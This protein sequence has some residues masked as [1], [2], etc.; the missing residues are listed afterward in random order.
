MDKCIMVGCDLHDKS[1]LL[2][3]AS[4]RLDEAPAAKRLWANNAGAR[5]AMRADLQRRAAEVGARR[6][7]F[8]YEASGLGFGLHDELTAAGIECHVLAPTKMERSIKN[9]FGKTDERDADAVLRDV[10]SYVLSGAELP[11]VWV[12][13]LSIR[14]DREP[15]RLRLEAADKLTR[16]KCQIRCLL[17]RSGVEQAASSAKPWTGE[18]VRWLRT[19]GESSGR[20]GAGA[21]LASL[22]RQMDFAVEE[23]GRLDAVVEAL[24]KTARYAPLM[25]AMRTKG[26]G[27]LTAMVLATELGDFGRFKNRRQFGAFL[28]LAPRSD[29]SGQTD[30]R[31]GRITRQGPSRVRK[32]LNQAIWSRVRAGG[33]DAAKYGRIAA[34]NPKHKKKAV[35][36]VMRDLGIWE[37]HRGLEAQLQMGGGSSGAAGPGGPGG[38]GGASGGPK[39]EVPV[40]GLAGA[41]AAAALRLPGPAA[42]GA[43]G[44][45]P[46]ERC[47]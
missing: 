25:A 42:A 13:P 24:S 45:A 8:A 30:D 16:I 28:G 22:L 37:W 3:I 21:A 17:K 36:A 14:D 7:V 43:S 32:V 5:R 29:E 19:W 40:V 31:K 44:D 33:P 39:R 18:Y 20:P 11:E 27:L 1:M 34:R 41:A 10:V 35:V 26:V 9:L 46:G 4:G 23:L 15:V 6:I 12:P 47:G 2:K 38:V